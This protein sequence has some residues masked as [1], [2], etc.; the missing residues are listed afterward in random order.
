MLQALPGDNASILTEFAEN[1]DGKPLSGSGDVVRAVGE[2]RKYIGVTLEETAL[3]GIAAGYDIEIVYPEEGTSAL[4]DG[5]AIVAGCAHRDNAE[6]F[7]D[8]LLSSDMQTLLHDSLYR[9]SVCES[10][11]N[12]GTDEITLIDYD[13][14]WASAEQTGLLSLWRDITGGAG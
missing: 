13:L 1:L 5:A 6:L 14:E 10:A 8:F 7:I 11:A 2:G 12:A 3:K 9:R 4:P